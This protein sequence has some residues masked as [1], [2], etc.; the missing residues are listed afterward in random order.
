M[1]ALIVA[2]L[3]VVGSAVFVAGQWCIARN[4]L[5]WAEEQQARE[6]RR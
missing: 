4:C 1:T 3:A 2:T 6:A 5:R